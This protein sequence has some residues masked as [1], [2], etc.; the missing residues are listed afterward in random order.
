MS[1]QTLVII[2][3]VLSIVAFSLMII[4][5]LIELKSKGYL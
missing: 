5:G 1:S 4:N 2:G 3:S